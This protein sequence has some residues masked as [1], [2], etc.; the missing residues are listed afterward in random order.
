MRKT[1][2]PHEIVPFLLALLPSACGVS[3]ATPPASSAP[4]DS[5]LLALDRD[6][7]GT[8]DWPEVR[9]GASAKFDKLDSDHDG[10]LD[11]KELAAVHV[12]PAAFDRADKSHDGTLTKD[13]YL[14]LVHD[15]FNAADPDKD[16]TVSAAE[17]QTQSGQALRLLIE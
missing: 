14:S 15:A 7:D 12:D 17:L 9:S 2:C 11:V 5:T 6:K 4:A 8:L 16:G 1:I 3:G 13:E 10:T